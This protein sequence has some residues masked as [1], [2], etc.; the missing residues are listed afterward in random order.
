VVVPNNILPPI[1][2]EL[3]KKIKSPVFLPCPAADTVT[4]FALR[5]TEKAFVIVTLADTGVTSTNLSP[6]CSINF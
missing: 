2:V 3:V 6:S 4:V 5:A 1:V